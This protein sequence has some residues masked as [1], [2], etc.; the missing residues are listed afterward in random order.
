M[1]YSEADIHDGAWW[2]RWRHLVRAME[3]EDHAN[4]LEKAFQFQLALVSNGSLGSDNF[5]AVQKEAKEIFRD[6]EGEMKPWT[7]RRTRAQRQQSEK[8]MYDELWQEVTGFSMFD[9]SAFADWE[10]K[11][12]EATAG[13][14]ERLQKSQR[15]QDEQKANFAKRVQEIKKKRA[16]QQG[17]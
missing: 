8:D 5:S 9:K 17:R 3:S 2:Q 14:Q 10:E 11:L 6:I 15:E 7:N 13:S 4:L 12:K 16:R 1:D